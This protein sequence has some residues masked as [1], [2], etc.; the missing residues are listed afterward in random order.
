MPA[1]KHPAGDLD[2]A[3]SRRLLGYGRQSIAQQ[4]IDAVIEVLRS[5]YLT[6]GPTVERFEAAL[7]EYVGARYA[8]AVSSGTAALHVA[9]LAARLGAGGHAV[10]QAVTFVATANAAVA[11]AGTV[12]VTDIDVVTLG[13]DPRGLQNALARRPDVSLVLPVH[14]GGLSADPAT[15]AAASA[16]RSVINPG[17]ARSEASCSTGWCVGPSSPSPIESWV[18]IQ[19][20]GISMRALSRIAGRA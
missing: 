9:Y 13:M 4:D 7:A 6:Q 10:T 15:I 5:D 12:S 17:M 1:S 16:G 19:M 8:V 3:A 11:C 18:K 2:Q 14:M 20:V